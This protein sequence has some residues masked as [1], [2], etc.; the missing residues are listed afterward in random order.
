M[1]NDF[2]ILIAVIFTLLIIILIHELGHFCMARLFNIKIQRL[3]IGFGKPAFTIKGKQGTEYT[4]TYFPLGGYVKLADAR[5]GNMAEADLPFAFNRQVLWKKLLVVI[6][7]PVANFMLALLL[8]WAIFLVGYASPKP[9]IGTVMPASVA[10]TAGLQANMEIIQIGNK[11]TRNQQDVFLALFPYYESAKQVDFSVNN[12]PQRFILNLSDWHISSLKPQ[13]LKSLGIE[14][15]H[16]NKNLSWPQD[17]LLLAKYNFWNAAAEAGK[18]VKQF[19]VFNA[20]IIG[21]LLTGK[22]SLKILAGPMSLFKTVQYATA[23]GFLDFLMLLAILSIGIGFI[24]LLP[25]PSLDGGQA[26]IMIIEKIMN[27]EMS[28]PLQM[29]LYRLSLIVFFILMAQAVANDLLRV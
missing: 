14:F 19:T 23:Q 12:Q 22:L 5:A 24:N 28:L 11:I 13:L 26:L 10:A 8:Y 7:G 4:V 29:L 6:A 27:K 1:T 15:W 3:S 2:L 25:V 9:I 17:K 16:P 20:E 21:K 18:S